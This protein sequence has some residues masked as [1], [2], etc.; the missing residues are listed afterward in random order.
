MFLAYHSEVRSL[1]A[2]EMLTAT[3][4]ANMQVN[5]VVKI[6]WL[7]KNGTPCRENSYK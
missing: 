5:S 7:S 1:I 6:S 2:Q 3:V 4:I